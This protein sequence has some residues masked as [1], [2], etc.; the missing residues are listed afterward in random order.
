MRKP[1][2]ALAA[3]SAVMAAL[4]TASALASASNGPAD[5]PGTLATPAANSSGI[6]G[7]SSGLPYH[8]TLRLSGTIRVPSL[9]CSGTTDQSV[10]TGITANDNSNNLNLFEVGLAMRCVNGGATFYP[11][12]NYNGPSQLG[13]PQDRALP[14]DTIQL[15]VSLTKAHNTVSVVDKTHYFNV[16]YG[17]GGKGYGGPWLGVIGDFPYQPGAYSKPQPVPDFGKLHFSQVLFNGSPIGSEKGVV[18]EQW[19]GKIATSALGKDHESFTTTFEH[20]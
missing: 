17:Q 11:V 16:S 13:Y 20:S 12:M 4:G 3:A 2:A 14:G 1:L 9:S 8:A 19:N 15:V 5:A 7:Y 10:V 18:R 6:A